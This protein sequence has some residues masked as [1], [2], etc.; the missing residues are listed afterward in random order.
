M[1]SQVTKNHRI[2]WDC[3][4]SEHGREDI[5]NIISLYPSFLSC[6]WLLF[7]GN[8]FS[9]GNSILR[10]KEFLSCKI[11]K[12]FTAWNIYLLKYNLKKWIQEVLRKNTYHFPLQLKKIECFYFE[13]WT[14]LILM[15]IS[16]IHLDSLSH[17][18]WYN[19]QGF[20][21]HLNGEQDVSVRRDTNACSIYSP[22]MVIST[23]IISPAW[24]MYWRGI[25][26]CT[27][28]EIN[29]KIFLLLLELSFT[30]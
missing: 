30:S 10:W 7:I 6:F 18:I 24:V 25:L 23:Y 26:G 20:I 21:K 22:C 27:G 2:P 9:E 14:Y 19:R 1:I 29:R 16:L 8:F 17:S 5:S 15:E 4:H 3:G 11:N 28:G 13:D 12:T